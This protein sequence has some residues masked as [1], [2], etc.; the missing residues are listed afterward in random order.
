MHTR[1]AGSI[2]AG[3]DDRKPPRRSD[4]KIVSYLPEPELDEPVCPS[5]ITTKGRIMR[6]LSILAAALVVSAASLSLRPAAAAPLS[7]DQSLAAPGVTPQPVQYWRHRHG[8]HHHGWHH[9][10]WRHGYYG[11]G[12][13]IGG[14]AAGAVI[15]SAIAGSQARAADGDAYCFRRFKSYDPASGTYL[16]YDGNRH[17]CP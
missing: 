9:H 15:G 4:A 8:W 12:P 16:G 11:P 1:A 2:A 5:F 10:G 14:L 6:L 13:V 7:I 17:P 3:I